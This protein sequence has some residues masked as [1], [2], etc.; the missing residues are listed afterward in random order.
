MPRFQANLGL[1]YTRPIVAD[2][3]GVAGV[4]VTFRGRENSYFSSALLQVSPP[5]PENVE[6]SPYSLVNLRLGIIKDRWSVTAF[7]RNLTDKR[8]QISAINSTQDPD[9][10]LT[11]RPRTIGLTVTR[12]F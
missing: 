8:A 3:Q 12:K 2:W 9:A 6:L 5:I 10:L 4:D 11:V 1:N 7:A